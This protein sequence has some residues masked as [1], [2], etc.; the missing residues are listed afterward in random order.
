VFII[1]VKPFR[2]LRRNILEIFNETV[3]AIILIILAT[4]A[5]TSAL[6]GHGEPAVASEST[7]NWII[8]LV[9]LMIVVN[10]L[11]ATI[12]FPIFKFIQIK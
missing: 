11:C 4:N 6:T 1:V 2:I 8:G 5:S 10:I 7:G 9:W 3:I 12:I